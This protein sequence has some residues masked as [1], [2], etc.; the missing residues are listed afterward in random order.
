M[1]AKADTQV[2]RGHLAETGPRG[3]G[4]PAALPLSINSLLACGSGVAS[5][6]L[7][8]ATEVLLTN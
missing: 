5:N 3:P 7:I 8:Y 4:A 2:E 1:E 6:S